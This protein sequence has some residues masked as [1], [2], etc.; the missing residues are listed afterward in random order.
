MTEEQ[1]AAQAVLEDWRITIRELDTLED[2]NA[3]LP[4][5]KAAPKAAQALFAI[6]AKEKGYVA[7]KKA[8]AYVAAAANQSQEKVA[9]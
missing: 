8:G 1:T 9:A 5:L 4:E 3:K 2:F 7:D 6:A